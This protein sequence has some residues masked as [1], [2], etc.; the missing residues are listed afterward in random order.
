MTTPRTSD[1]DRLTDIAGR[2]LDTAG[3]PSV[4]GI[5]CPCDDIGRLWL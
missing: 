3:L 5:D 1:A 4:A 2:G